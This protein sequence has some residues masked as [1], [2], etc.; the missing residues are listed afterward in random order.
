M[1]MKCYPCCKSY[2]WKYQFLILRIAS[3]FC[4]CLYWFFFVFQSGVE[5]IASPA[6]SNNDQSVVD[7]CNENFITMVHTNMRLFHH[8][9]CMRWLDATEYA[10][11]EKVITMV[12]KN[13]RLFHHWICMRWLD[14]TEYA[15]HGLRFHHLLSVYTNFWFC[16]QWI[17]MRWLSS[18]PIDIHSMTKI[19]ACSK[20]NSV[21]AVSI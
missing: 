20:D 1:T 8:W 18:K 2:Q 7:A 3:F 11:K 9:I 6:G 16:I 12:P 10:C 17:I 4:V 14:A 21:F 19:I 13:M 5:F 15:W